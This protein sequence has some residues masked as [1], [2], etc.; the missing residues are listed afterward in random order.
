MSELLTNTKDA[1]ARH[2]PPKNYPLLLG[3]CAYPNYSKRRRSLNTS[4]PFTDTF[5]SGCDLSAAG[6]VV[7]T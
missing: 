1:L 6:E 5:R 3:S 2:S 4:V 7:E